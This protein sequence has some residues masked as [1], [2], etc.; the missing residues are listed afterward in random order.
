VSTTEAAGDKVEEFQVSQ[1]ERF[2]HPVGLGYLVF[3]EAWERFSYYGMQALLVL[4][5]TKQ[6]L[7]VGHIENVAGFDG[8]KEVVGAINSFFRFLLGRGAGEALSTPIAIGAAITGAYSGLVYLTP[9]FGGF[10]ADRFIGRTAAVTLGAILMVLGHFLMAFEVSFVAAITCLVLGVGFFKGNIASQVGELYKA[11]DPRRAFAF[12]TFLLGVQIAVIVAPLVCGF[13]GEK[14][15]WHWGF[16]AAGVGMTVGLAVYLSGRKY[17]PPDRVLDRRKLAGQAP[18]PKLVARDWAT[19]GVL[20]LL[21]P[22]LSLTALGNQEIFNA[23]LLWGDKNFQLTFFG[24]TMP[25]SSLV[26]LDAFV[27]MITMLSVMAFWRWYGAKRREPDE[28]FKIV[29]GALISAAAPLLLALASA[30]AAL[31]HERVSLAWGLGFHIVNDIGFAMVFPVGLALFSRVAPK[32]TAGVIIG[33]Y[34]VHLFICNGATGYL[35]GLIETMDGFSFW[36]MHAGLIA[37]GGAIMLGFAFV[38]R[39]ILAP[40]EPE[41]AAAVAPVPA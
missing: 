29:I 9:L 21:V 14:V 15:A 17:L 31:T 25:T 3:A 39:G 40:K 38:F 8:F 20:I 4:Y 12:Q 34:Y 16:G 27:S 2:G 36:A 23:Y 11:G 41:P 24:F 1:K 35:A 26:S 7:L 30:E 10:I 32:G 22:L 19:I 6:L 13:L 28:I 37:L 33:V 5:L 18:A